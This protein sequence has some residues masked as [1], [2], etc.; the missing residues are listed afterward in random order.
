MRRMTV[1][2]F[3]L[4]E[5][6]VVIGIIGVLAAI[7]VPSMIG[8][9]SKSK[10]AADVSSAR[11]A[12]MRTIDIMVDNSD[13]E[14]SF[15]SGGSTE[16]ARYDNVEG[17]SYDL[18]LVS[19]LDGL[20]GTNGAGKVWT[21]VDSTQQDFCDALNKRMDY[22]SSD[23]SIKQKIKTKDSSLG[24]LNRWY[25]GYRKSN[26][27]T[28]EIWIGDANLNGSC[29]EPLMCLYTQI[30]KSNTSSDG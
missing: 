25:I 16:F 18:I 1:K 26:P 22:S 10:R 23:T 6:I 3:S 17:V 14:D 12:Y 27:K 7:L 24:T 29:G 9:V 5:L 2:G 19:Y 30:N 8:Y 28:V 15:Y 11:E 20:G 21:P 4:I 13:V